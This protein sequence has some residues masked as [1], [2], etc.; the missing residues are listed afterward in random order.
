MKKH[1]TI[2]HLQLKSVLDGKMVENLPVGLF[3]VNVI[4]VNFL[5]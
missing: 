5:D 1:K 4:A 3:E 2:L